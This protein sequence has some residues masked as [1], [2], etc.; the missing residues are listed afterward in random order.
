[1]STI[2]VLTLLWIIFSCFDGFIQAHYYDLTPSEKGHKNLHPFFMVIRSLF[3]G[4]IF[5]EVMIVSIWELAGI[6]TFSLSLIF[7][8]FHNGCYY[9]TR[10]KLNPEVYKKGF[11]D[12]STTSEAILEIG[13]GFRTIMAIVGLIF[14][15]VLCLELI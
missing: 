9:L 6:F 1:M 14:I 5:Y 12:S 4:I 15:Y 11:W 13:T 3:L 7:S 10:N 8:F 2:I